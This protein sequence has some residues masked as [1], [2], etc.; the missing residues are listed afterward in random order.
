MIS[1]RGW[2]KQ[3]LDADRNDWPSEI[4]RS[5]AL[6][7][8]DYLRSA[9]RVALSLAGQLC[10]DEA[11]GRERG[12]NNRH[13]RPTL[14]APGNDWAD[15]AVVHLS[16]NEN[17]RIVGCDDPPYD[18]V[19]V[20]P[21]PLSSKSDPR[22]LQAMLN[23]LIPDQTLYMKDDDDYQ[24]AA[25]SVETGKPNI[26][27][28]HDFARAEI[29]LSSTEYKSCDDD[30][31]G[32]E[33][34]RIY[35]LGLVFYELFSGG[36]R[37][38]ETEVVNGQTLPHNAQANAIDFLRQL[39]FFDHPDDIGDSSIQTSDVHTMPRKKKASHILSTVGSIA[40][41]TLKGK[42][43]PISLCNL[44]GNMLDCVNGDLSGREA[45]RTMSDVR[46]DLK[47]MLDKPDRFLYD[48][49]VEKLAVTGL[50]L[51]E[52]VFDRTMEFCD[53]HN[54]YMRSISGENE[55][56]VIV[57]PSGIGKTVLANRLGSFASADGALFLTGKFDQLQQSTPFS[58]LAS[59]F[60]EYCNQ[61][62]KDGRDSHLQ[63][64]A[65]ELRVA[66]GGEA[67]HLVK[68]IPNLGIILGEGADHYEDQDCANAQA[69]IQHLLCL[70]VDVISSSS[71]MPI[72]LFLDDLQWSDRASLSAINH[73]LKFF[74]TS[75]NSERQFFFLGSCREEALMENHPFGSALISI[76]QFGVHA[77][78]IK[79]ACFDKDTT[80][81]MVSDLLCLS[82]R[83]TRTLSEIIHHKSQGNPFFF[84]QL[85]AS[86]YRDGLVRLSLSHRR[87]EWDEDK[88]QSTKL[89]DDVVALL[90]FTIERSSNE[91]QN[92]L[93]ALSCFGA[94]SDSVIMKLLEAKLSIPLIEP[95]QVAVAE[96]IVDMVDGSYSFSH[97]RLQEAAYSMM[98]P[99]DRCLFHFKYGVALVP[100][101]LDLEDDAMLFIAAN[102]INLGGIAPVKDSEQA[103]LIANLNLTA[104]CKAM[105]MSDFPSAF[106]FLDHGISFLPKG[107]WQDHYDL[108]IQIF[109]AAS[110]CAL[111][112]GN[113]SSFNLLTDQSLK[114]A[115]RFEDKL[116]TML[117]K[118]TALSSTS[119]LSESFK[120]G[121]DVLSQ[122]GESLPESSSETD[123]KFHVEQTMIMLQ[124]FSEERELIEYKRMT[125]LYKIMAMK[126]LW[127]LEACSQFIRQ[128][129]FPLVT[130]KMVQLS[131]AHGM[132]PVSS[133]GF[134]YF[135]QLV[136]KLGYFRE[137][138]R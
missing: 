110:R 126:F 4:R 62:A 44:I 16:S 65:S 95:L 76:R 25:E 114:S 54:S 121:I 30:C 75:S 68:V 56:A 23:F 35:S 117:S 32:V 72:L 122:L 85:M 108:S 13:R 119:K 134:A 92:A 12:E 123:V 49:D 46:T 58:A 66:L 137:G 106:S 26:A 69:R 7:S 120:M 17:N 36:E 86:I 113:F 136:A 64:I 111:V 88:I 128:E 31:D 79:L 37:H 21:L 41:E 81:R 125:D 47:L 38:L 77:A 24:A 11:D 103:L 135:G 43:V 8:D 73:L 55:F 52:A 97:D 107:H 9:L 104:G 138:C 18:E 71:R 59:A 101:A 22:E 78:V 112:N 131:I 89:P 42:G 80:N 96:G 109:D 6:S 39:N 20:Q 129:I 70:F 83:L 98:N 99:E 100:S 118:V 40:I 19:D 124:R 1:L 87:W 132:S 102:Q 3:A 48:M 91:V 14:P 5:L 67:R 2:V 27:P 45:Y 34:H 10:W 90:S 133:I 15:R 105:E 94:R 61:M 84:S 74:R 29:L 130:V 28:C 33:I 127:K 115:K 50:Q 82:P 63:V 57:G 51:N 53:L 116:N 93:C 60:N